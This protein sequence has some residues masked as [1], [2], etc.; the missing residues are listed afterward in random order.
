[1]ER[2]IQEIE[3][4]FPSSFDDGSLARLI[5]ALPGIDEEN[6]GLFIKNNSSPSRNPRSEANQPPATMAPHHNNGTWKKGPHAHT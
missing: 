3:K 6:T 2:A 5:S 1:M 4:V